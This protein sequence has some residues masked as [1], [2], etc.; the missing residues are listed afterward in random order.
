M[1]IEL[2]RV[3]DDLKKAEERKKEEAAALEEQ[4]CLGVEAE[5]KERKEKIEQN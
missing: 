1:E 2:K 4:A 3:E 5:E